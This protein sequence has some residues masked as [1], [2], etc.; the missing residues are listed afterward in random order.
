MEDDTSDSVYVYCAYYHDT[1]SRQ[2]ATR[3]DVSDVQLLRWLHKCADVP[4]PTLHFSEYQDAILELAPQYYHDY[5]NVRTISGVK[6][7]YPP[8]DL[9]EEEIIDLDTIMA[10][11]IKRL[12]RDGSSAQDDIEQ[13]VARI[14]LISTLLDR[15]VPVEDIG[16]DDSVSVGN[17]AL[18]ID[19]A[20]MGDQKF[21]HSNQS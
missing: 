9:T 12:E 14:Y 20:A 7:Y 21:E 13:T 17:K 11:E 15:Y 8:P 19:A 18:N 10:N 3:V 4:K 1:Q 16:D 5:R 2:G 6:A